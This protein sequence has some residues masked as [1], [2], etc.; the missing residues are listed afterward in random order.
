MNLLNI[1]NIKSLSILAINNILKEAKL[2]EQFPNHYQEVLSNSIIA[3]LFYEPST[4]TSMSFQTAIYKMNGKNLVFNEQYSS[5]QKGESIMDTVKTIENY[6][7]AL[8]IRHPEKGIIDKISKITNKPIIN[9]GDG[10]GDHPTQ[11]LLDL[12]TILQYQ[13]PPFSIAF[14]GDIDNS[15]T[16]HSLIDLL[17]KM[18]DDIFYYFIP[19]DNQKLDKIKIIK[20]KFKIVYTLDEIISDIDVISMTR[21]QKERWNHN[22]IINNININESLLNKTK[23]TTILMHPLPRNS[24]IPESLD[25]HPKSKYFEQAKNGVVV[26]MAILKYILKF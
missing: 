24:E 26:R 9:A 16:I 14:T 6:A 17:D 21:L 23:D 1:I 18:Y 19:C 3:S 2:I 8:I 7:D 5:T 13:Q 10:N 4:R 15:R 22:T 25:D 20:N 11:S 12:Y